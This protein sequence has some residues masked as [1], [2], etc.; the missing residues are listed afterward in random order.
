VWHRFK[1]LTTNTAD[2]ALPRANLK[3]QPGSSRRWIT[4]FGV[5]LPDDGSIEVETIVGTRRFASF[6]EARDIMEA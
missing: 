4:E 6:A 1:L 2:A 3:D 5:T